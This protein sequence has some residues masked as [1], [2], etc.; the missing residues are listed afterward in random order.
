MDIVNAYAALGSYRGAAA[1]CGTTHKTVKRVLERRAQGQA[2]RRPAR[3]ANTAGVAALLEERVRQ[4]D[5]RISAKR[6]LPVAQ[7][8]GYAGSLRSLQRAVMRVKAAWQK[9]RRTYRPWVPTPGEH[10]V[11]DWASEGG[12]ELFC[13]VLAWSRYRFVRMATD[14]TRDTTLRLLA[15]C[16]EDLGG[17]PAVVLTDRM[18]CL[19]AGTVANVVVPHPEYVEFATRYGFRP[20]FCEA[21]DPESKGVVEHLAGYAQRDLLVPT[22]PDGGWPDLATATAAAVR[23]CAEVNGRVHSEIAAV[24]AERLGTE[25][26][27]LRPLPSLRPPLR[28]GEP[29]KVDRTGMVRFGA[30]RYA[31]PSA[32]VGV[33]VQVR[34]EEGAVVI[35]RDGTEVLR[36]PSV[37]PGEVAL[38]P[39]AAE[40]RRPTRGVRP[41]TATEVAFL[42]LGGA[43]ESFLRAAAAAGTLRPETE[44][45][46]VVAL[47][48]AWGGAPL[49]RALQR[50]TT[51]R[52]FTAA[53]VRSILEAGPGVPEPA[54]RG[55]AG[56]Q[57]ALDLPLVTER[58]LSAYALAHVAPPAPGGGRP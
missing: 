12:W 17:V 15:E 2:G 45:A 50:A 10:L 57:L 29:R 58:P 7:A 27:V 47:A 19:R 54:P 4:T 25:R 48:A 44:L 18:G 38:G 33:V 23:W 36:H 8:A 22:L 14:Q 13:A 37:G 34:A 1:L 5:G 30:A 32:L 28:A 46:Q 9:T 31:V 35:T 53:A 20:D 42:G 16:F 6:L 39:F 40:A 55:R 51:Y 26:G 56:T 24:P 11:V 21:A 41:R 3:P 49:L 43:A 52:R